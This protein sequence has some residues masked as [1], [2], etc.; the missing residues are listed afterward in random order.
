MTAQEPE[1]GKGFFV[2]MEVEFTIGPAKKG[3]TSRF[4]GTIKQLPGEG[5]E[6]QKAEV[7]TSDGWKLNVPFDR[8]KKKG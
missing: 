4:Y 3:R 6:S 2:G 8:L 1:Q 7:I 5:D